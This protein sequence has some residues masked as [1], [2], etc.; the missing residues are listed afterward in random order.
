MQLYFKAYF[1]NVRTPPPDNYCTLPNCDLIIAFQIL[2]MSTNTDKFFFC[3]F[4]IS[5][6]ICQEEC[7]NGG[8]CVGPDKCACLYGFTG[9]RCQQGKKCPL[10]I[11]RLKMFH[12][13]FS[14][15]VYRR[16]AT[17]YREASFLRQELCK[18]NW[19]IK[20]EL[21]LP[22]KLSKRCLKE[23]RFSHF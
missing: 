10:Y 2:Q 9:D 4:F 23:L 3:Y 19:K 22:R 5:K 12:L 7:L 15:E 11:F 1:A 21:N 13:G 16:N 18:R 14:T 8:R 17:A 6:A 20:R